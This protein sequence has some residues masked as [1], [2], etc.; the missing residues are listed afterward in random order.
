MKYL[1]LS[2]SADDVK[3]YDN[4][5]QDSPKPQQ[6]S[7]KPMQKTPKVAQ[8]T[9]KLERR[10]SSKEVTQNSD[11]D[12]DVEWKS[13][14]VSSNKKTPRNRSKQKILTHLLSYR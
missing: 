14:A 7:P 11:S 5:S 3:R 13:K 8:T 6:K 12:S 10:K 9:P 1:Y 2:D 4:E